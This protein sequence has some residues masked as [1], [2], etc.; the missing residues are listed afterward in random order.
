MGATLN[1]QQQV[2]MPCGTAGRRGLEGG[3]CVMGSVFGGLGGAVAGA[4]RFYAARWAW[5]Q[6]PKCGRP[7][8]GGPH[9]AGPAQEASGRAMRPRLK[10][11]GGR[12]QSS[13]AGFCCGSRTACAAECKVQARDGRQQGQMG[14]VGQRVGAAGLHCGWPCSQHHPWCSMG[15]SARETPER[16]AQSRAAVQPGSKGAQRASRTT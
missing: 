12:P 3:G 15:A 2:P 6:R 10:R 8:V 14:G 5:G 16:H 11:A 1:G 7:A 13:S 9:G 4:F